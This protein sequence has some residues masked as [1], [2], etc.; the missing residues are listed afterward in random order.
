MSNIYI[1]KRIF[2]LT[3]LVFLIMGLIHVSAI[4]NSLYFYYRWLDIPAHFLGGLGVGLFTIWL[5]LYFEKLSFVFGDKIKTLTVLFLSI[6]LIGISWEIFEYAFDIAVL[7]KSIYITDTI[8][9]ILVDILGTLVAY[10]YY[11]K[12]FGIMSLDFKVIKED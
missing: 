12:K 1:R 8:K 5:F 7:D 2:A 3:L 6:I 9:D 10:S 11:V 4:F